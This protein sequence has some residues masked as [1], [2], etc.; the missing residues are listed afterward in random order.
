MLAA[1]PALA[2]TFGS[3]IRVDAANGRQVAQGVERLQ[4][5]RASGELTQFRTV[6]VALGTDGPLTPALFSELVTQ[7][8]GVPNLIFYDTYDKKPWEATTNAAL[9]AGVPANPGMIELNWAAV[10]GAPGLVNADGTRPT[11]AG[12]TAFASMLN[13]ILS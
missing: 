13:S 6:V 8:Q 3:A 7:L 1:K 10:A 9:A 5:Y 11:A 4:E 12:A 2:A